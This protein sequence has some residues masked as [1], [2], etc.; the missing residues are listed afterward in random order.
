MLY[1]LSDSQVKNLNIFLQ[2]VDLKG[3]E[4]VEFALVI[5]ALSRPYEQTKELEKKEKVDKL[6]KK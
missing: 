1:E 6:D 2:R 3:S 5:S 4:A